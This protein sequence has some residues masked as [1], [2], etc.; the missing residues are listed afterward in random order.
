MQIRS[1]LHYLPYS[2]IRNNNESAYSFE[3]PHKYYSVEQSK[4]RHGSSHIWQSGL[5]SCI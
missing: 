1:L 2:E 5:R 4:F 3:Y